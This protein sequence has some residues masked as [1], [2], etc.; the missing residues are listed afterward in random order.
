MSR[1]LSRL[2]RTLRKDILALL[3]RQGLPV[4]TDGLIAT[5]SYLKADVRKIHGSSRQARLDEECAFVR[6]WLPRVW[7]YFASG[8]EVVPNRID[9]YLVMLGP[10]KELRALFRIASLWWSVPVSRGFGRRLRFVVLDRSNG[11]LIGLLGLTDPVF[12]LAV[13]DAWVGWSVKDREK[14]LAH[15][16]DAYVL[17]AVP[18]YNQLLGAKLVALLAVSDSV[19][20][21]FWKRYRKRRSVI[22]NRMFDGRLAMLTATSSLGPSSIYNRLRFD[23]LDVFRPVG[24]TEGYGHFHLANGT[25][26][27]LHE[28]LTAMGDDEVNRYK[29]GRGPNYRIRVV[30]RALRH[31]NLRSDLLRHGIRRAVYVAPFAH[32]ATA[33]LQGNAQHLRWLKRPVVDLM[34]TWR[35]RWLLP[36]AA[37]DQSFRTFNKDEWLE[38]LSSDGGVGLSRVM[39][40]ID[41]ASGK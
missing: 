19:R 33:F 15:V 7:K 27:R 10:D 31:L 3:E 28:Y 18:P 14:R 2:G 22:R 1:A 40:M 21:A 11:K 32:N 37:R 30:R 8:S 36:R 23:G 13:R 29:F 24:F 41:S 34:A 17:G 12:N 25:Y 39:P 26:V 9:P 16:V 4:G 5:A 38:I 20:A 35:E 6:Q